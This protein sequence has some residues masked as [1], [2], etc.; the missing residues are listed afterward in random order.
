M[1]ARTGSTVDELGA[2]RL[3]RAAGQ[4]SVGD[5]ARS[6]R[7]DHDAWLGHV[8]G[9]AGCAHPIRLAGTLTHV[10]ASTGRI[11]AERHTS[12]MPDGVLYTPCGNRRANVCAGCAETYRA[13]T[14][15]LV[16]AGLMGGKTVPTTVAQHPCVFLTV[17]APS[18]GPV[19]AHCTDR[20]GRTLPCRPR[21]HLEHCEHGHALACF[22]RHDETADEIGRPLCL[23]CYDHPHQAVWNLYSGELWRRTMI[24][25]RRA[26][27]ALERRHGIK[28]RL[29]YTKVA[30]F[31]HRGAV[32]F[33]ALV[34]LDGR[35]PTDA[36]AILVPD[37]RVGAHH[38]ATVLADAVADTHLTT[39]AHPARALGW[40]IAWGEQVDPRPVRLSR[41]DLDDTGEITTGAVAGYLAKYATKA[42]ELAGHVSSRLRP[43]TVRDYARWDTHPGR[44]ID[45]CWHLGTRPDN[46]DQAGG[47]EQDT[48][49][50]R[51]EWAETWG[52][53]QRWAH[54]L[55]F[56][57]HFSTRSQRYSTTMRA[58]RQARRD[59]RRRNA[60]AGPE[61]GEVDDQADEDTTEVV[62]AS[63]AFA[64]IG[65]HTS[66]DA[67]LANT[68]AANARARRRAARDELT[69]LTA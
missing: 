39:A 26:V 64:G 19:H 63:L 15:Q 58:L 45:T 8:A 42:T 28:L 55:G 11:T 9:A 14:Y 2:R 65:W 32:H 34:R 33:H 52:R 27:K 53:L 20:A 12:T 40:P 30:E 56:G 7:A 24:A 61:R 44:Q 16:T 13:D 46:A 62:V 41:L 59:W 6:I 35:D 54:M 25:A 21:R 22:T 68:S 1:S 10:E 31:Q 5:L 17:T 60:T 29:S 48:E 57:G 47:D 4:A 69:S 37:A 50:D 66:A 23:D 36:D 43:D 3:A 38:V 49:W 18:F 51:E 67:L